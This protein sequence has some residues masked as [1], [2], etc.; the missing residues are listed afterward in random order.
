M[1]VRILIALFVAATIVTIVLTLKNDNT[2]T[3]RKI[4]GRAIHDYHMDMKI[5]NWQVNYADIESYNA[6]LFRIWDWGYTNILPEEKFEII[7]PYILEE[8]K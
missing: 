5:T 3:K 7:K 6:T 2:Y 8:H 4:I 1:I